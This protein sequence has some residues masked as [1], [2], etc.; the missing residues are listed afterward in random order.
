MKLKGKVNTFLFLFFRKVVVNLLKMGIGR[1]RG[2]NIVF[3]FIYGKLK[4]EGIILVDVQGNRMYVNTIHYRP[5]FSGFTSL[6]RYGCYE[7]YTTKLFKEL[8]QEGMTIVDIGAYFGYYTLIASKLVGDSG[9]VYAFEPEP[10]N[11]DLLVRNISINN[12]YNVVSIQKAVSNKCGKTKLFV[13]QIN[14]GNPSFSENNVP[15]KRGFVEVETLTLDDFLKDEKV[16]FIK[17][18]TQGAE[19]LVIDGARRVLQSN[20]YMGILLEFWPFGLKNVGTDP[21]ELLR[22]LEC[23][24]FKVKLIDDANQCIKDMDRTEI[25]KLCESTKGGKGFVNLLLEK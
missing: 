16:D 8:V 2:M 1:I 10:S 21:S 20:I 11:Y 13:D 23:F 15:R 9:K 4:P 19:G 17:M 24:N 7:K 22:S 6:V 3:D 12:C 25:I 5:E 14:L 18:D